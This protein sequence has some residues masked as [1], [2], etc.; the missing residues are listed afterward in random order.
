MAAMPTLQLVPLVHKAAHRIAVYLQQSDAGVS[1]GEAH[2]LAHLV[3]QGDSTINDVHHAFGHRRSTLTNIVDRLEQN[4]LIEREI[5]AADRRT[6]LLR[7]TP[8]GRRAAR[9]IHRTL[10]RL[11][12][13]ALENVSKRDLQTLTS[14]LQVFARHEQA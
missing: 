12:A 14:V 10:A 1:Q 6:L 5:N 11:E 8:K 13:S 3:E 7:L 2:V 9:R 4:G